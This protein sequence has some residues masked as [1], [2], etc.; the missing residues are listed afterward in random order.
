MDR[1]QFRVQERFIG[2]ASQVRTVR[3]VAAGLSQAFRVSLLV[4]RGETA[5]VSIWLLSF[6]PSDPSL[7]SGCSPVAPVVRHHLGLMH[8]AL[9]PRH[10]KKWV[11]STF[12]YLCC[13]LSDKKRPRTFGR[14]SDSSRCGPSR[15]PL[16]FRPVLDESGP[17]LRLVS[18]PPGL[19]GSLSASRPSRIPSGPRR[20]ARSS[21]CDGT[22]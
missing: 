3:N 11:S 4:I 13:G 21:P 8:G 19:R 9:E 1:N 7:S 22:Y 12:A 20:P 5:K 14:V 10:T 18:D 17:E 2:T 16:S 15:S 6:K